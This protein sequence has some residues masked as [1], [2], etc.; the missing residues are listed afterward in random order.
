MPVALAEAHDLV[1]DRGA[2]AWTFARN[3]AGIHRRAVDIVADD[4][5]GRSVCAGDTELDLGIVDAL[6]QHRKRLWR[7][8]ARLHL[9][10]G[11]VNGATVEPRRRSGLEPPQPKSQSLQGQRQA[12]RRRLPHASRRRLLLA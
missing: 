4:A 10:R 12:E 7:L 11:P 9:H 6:G 1:L 8:V 5:V 2:I 3:L